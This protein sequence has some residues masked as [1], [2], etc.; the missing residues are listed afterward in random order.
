MI[1]S[2]ALSDPNSCWNKA[3]DDEMVFVILEHDVTAPDTVRDWCARRVRIGKNKP[4]DPQINRSL[5][6]GKRSRTTT[7]D[8]CMSYLPPAGLCQHIRRWVYG[9]FQ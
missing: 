2:K 7:N 4:G 6:V 3:K 5:G 8:V 9:L 1:K